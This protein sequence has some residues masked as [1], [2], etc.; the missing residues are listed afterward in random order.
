MS[1]PDKYPLCPYWVYVLFR[2][3]VLNN[4]R[5]RCRM[6][7]GSIFYREKAIGKKDWRVG[8]S[9]CLQFYF[10]DFRSFGHYLIFPDLD[11]PHIHRSSY[12]VTFF[13]WLSFKYVLNDYGVED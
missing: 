1:E 6:S 13:S 3:G 8:R 10:F 12:F 11:S 5:N 7:H 9:M 4:I 2:A